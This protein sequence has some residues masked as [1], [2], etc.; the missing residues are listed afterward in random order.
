M[1]ILN[2]RKIGFAASSLTFMLCVSQAVAQTPTPI[3]RSMLAGQQNVIT[4]A[5]PF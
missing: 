5:V 3:S 4:T 1:S 2:I